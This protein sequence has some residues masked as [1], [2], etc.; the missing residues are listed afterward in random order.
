MT[1]FLN[2]CQI[3]E[4]NFTLLFNGEQNQFLNKLIT[5]YESKELGKSIE[6]AILS[7]RKKI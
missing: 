2:Y 3:K 1:D 5:S 4:I 7:K 6:Y